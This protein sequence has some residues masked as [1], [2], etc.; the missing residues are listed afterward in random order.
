MRQEAESTFWAG[1]GLPQRFPERKERCMIH[2]I[3]LHC[4]LKISLGL[5]NLSL[6]HQSN[7]PTPVLSC[8][9]K[10]KARSF[11]ATYCKDKFESQE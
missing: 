6:R 7:M 5:V 4:E 3:D 9:F 11:T 2:S 1:V 10:S 8:V